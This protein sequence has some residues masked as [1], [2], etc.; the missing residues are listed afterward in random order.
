MPSFLDVLLSGAAAL[1]IYVCVGLPLSRSLTEYRA[2]AWALAPTLGWAVVSVVALPILIIVGWSRTSVTTLCGVAIIGGATAILRGRSRTDSGPSLPIWVYVAGGFFAIL[3]ALGLWPKLSDGGLVLADPLFDHSK[4]AIIDDIV[5]LGLPPGNPFY[6]GAEATPGLVYYYLWHF[7]AAILAKLVGASGWEADI[8][9]TWFTAFASLS[10]MTGLAV[11]ISGRRLAAPLTLL[12]NLA[13]SLGIILRL[14]LPSDLLGRLLSQVQAPNS[15][16]FQATWVPQHLASAGCAV[17]AVLILWRLSWSL[18]PLLAIVV[19]AGFESSAWVGGVVFG[20]GALAVGAALLIYGRSGQKRVEL[21]VQAGAAALLALVL[22]Y[23]FLRDEYLATAARQVGS[24]IV[25]HPYEVLGPLIPQSLRRVLDLPAYWVILLTVALPAIYPAGVAAMV[26]GAADG[27]TVSGERRLII[28]LA[29][30]SAASFGIPWLFA[31][32]I[33]NND[34]G[35][36]GVLPGILILTIFAAAGL[37]RWLTTSRIRAMAAIACLALGIPGGLAIVADN[38]TGHRL[39]SAAALAETPQM[40]AAVRHH[41]AL[42]ERVA[43]NPLFFFDSVGWP[44]NISWALFADRRSCFAGWNLARA[45]VPLPEAELDWLEGLFDRVFAG[46]GSSEDIAEIATSYDC[47][48]IVLTSRDG[49]WP[50]DPFAGNPRFRLVDEQP[51]KWRIYR[52]IAA[53]R[54]GR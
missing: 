4:I 9:L 43:N 39:P 51:E 41:T 44:V 42:D 3:P 6:G 21:I 45:F 31:S 29:L 16:I 20:A 5:R 48:V 40:W 38:A 46:D 17:L 24:P 2:L 19:A 15:W 26:G 1:A 35:W 23:P 32:T 8:A 28:P 18:V 25:F 13:A 53:T 11:A 52:V 10:L 27:D 12:L 50:H 49:A 47:R 34:L 36:R 37:S 54:E 30:L 7:S 14:V 33:A 22:T